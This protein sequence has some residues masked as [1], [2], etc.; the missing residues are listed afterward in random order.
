MRIEM[1]NIERYLNKFVVCDQNIG[2]VRYV[3]Q[4]SELP[5]DAGTIFALYLSYDTNQVSINL[6]QTINS[7]NSLY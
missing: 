4:I 5:N 3:G 6:K 7:K 1:T 2:R